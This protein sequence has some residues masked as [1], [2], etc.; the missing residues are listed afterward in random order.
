MIFATPENRPQ[1]PTTGIENNVL[2]IAMLRLSRVGP[3]NQQVKGLCGAHSAL[4][5]G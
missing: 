3:D 1:N 5:G 4:V 2:V